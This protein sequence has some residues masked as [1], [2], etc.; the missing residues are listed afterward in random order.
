M[1]G[2]D[3]LIHPIFSA[4]AQFVVRGAQPLRGSHRAFQQWAG[5]AAEGRTHRAQ[6]HGSLL[7]FA[8]DALQLF[9][10]ILE[11]QQVRFDVIAHPPERPG[12]TIGRFLCALRSGGDSSDRAGNSPG[13]QQRGGRKDRPHNALH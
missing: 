13:C 4:Q 2:L 7:R 12:Q 9:G 3:D 1:A 5:H 11:P 6:F 8:G 10:E